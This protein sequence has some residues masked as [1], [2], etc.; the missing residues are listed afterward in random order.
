MRPVRTVYSD[1]VHVSKDP[2]IDDLHTTRTE[3]GH[4]SVWVPSPE[5]REAI[6]NGA[7]VVLEVWS[8]PHPPVSVAVGYV[9]PLDDPES[10]QAFERAAQLTSLSDQP[11]ARA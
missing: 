11:E 2:E 7:N 4:Q 10:E 3:H 5:E 6:T 8:T 1:E 9:E